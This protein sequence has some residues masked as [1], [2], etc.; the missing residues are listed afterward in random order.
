MLPAGLPPILTYP[1]P[2]PLSDFNLPSLNVISVY[3]SSAIPDIAVIESNVEE[4]QTLISILSPALT[5]L[6][7]V[8]GILLDYV[9][10]ISGLYQTG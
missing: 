9:G 8:F 7:S 2:A 10:A 6:F 5:S 1:P 4:V 3:N